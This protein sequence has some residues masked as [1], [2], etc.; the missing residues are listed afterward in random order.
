MFPSEPTVDDLLYQ[1]FLL[2]CKV[3]VFRRRV[4]LAAVGSSVVDVILH[5]RA[6]DVTKGNGCITDRLSR[7]DA[8]YTHDG[9]QWTD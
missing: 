8:C 4:V 6:N 7:V 2:R 3:I 1:D 9:F 5:E